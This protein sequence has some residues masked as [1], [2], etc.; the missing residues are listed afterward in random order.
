MIFCERHLPPSVGIQNQKSTT[1]DIYSAGDS[2]DNF[3]DI[4]DSTSDIY[5]PGD[6]T[7]IVS[8]SI[9]STSENAA[10]D[11]SIKMELQNN[12]PSIIFSK[13]FLKGK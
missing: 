4:T 1:S 2:A 3:G 7:D 11:V 12:L 5:S 10:S 9:D 6:R 13:L 8:D